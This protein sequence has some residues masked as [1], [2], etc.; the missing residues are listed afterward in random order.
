[1]GAFPKV[2]AGLGKAAEALMLR[3]VSQ[4]AGDLATILLGTTRYPHS[5]RCDRH[6][7]GSAPRPKYHDGSQGT[8]PEHLHF[9][10]ALQV[11]GGESAM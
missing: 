5:L 4:E 10:D 8:N 11:R 2:R 7:C 3:H 1:M 6:T 9:L